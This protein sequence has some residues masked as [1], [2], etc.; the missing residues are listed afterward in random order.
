MRHTRRL[1]FVGAALAVCVV[2]LASP[3][4]SEQ[5]PTK[6][7]RMTPSGASVMWLLEANAERL[8]LTVSGGEEVI[9]RRFGR[10]EVPSVALQREQGGP[11]PDGIYSWELREEFEPVNDGVY[12]PENGRD[13]VDSSSAP[14]RVPLKGRLQSGSFTIRGGSVVAPNLLERSSGSE[15]DE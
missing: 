3:V 5:K 13:S 12:D 15:N 9:E 1:T 8:V 6:L 4:L 14:E 2:T 11:L 7:A 10:G